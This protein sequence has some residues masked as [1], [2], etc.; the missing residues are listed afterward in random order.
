[1]C[2]SLAIANYSMMVLVRME[3]PLVICVV[4]R[5]RSPGIEN[6]P[7]F[8]YMYYYF[9]VPLQVYSSTAGVIVAVITQH[10]V[11]VMIVVAVVVSTCVEVA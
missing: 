6:P 3:V 8:M 5:S 9:A 2:I 1:M 4:W 11:V 10:Q 7:S